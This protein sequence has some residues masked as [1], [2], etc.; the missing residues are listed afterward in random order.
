MRSS[1]TGVY[2]ADPHFAMEVPASRMDDYLEAVGN[3]FLESLYITRDMGI[4]HYVI[5]GDLFNKADTPGTV[6]NRVIDILAR[7]NDGSPWPFRVMM[8]LGNHDIFGHNRLTIERTTAET[9]N[10]TGVIDIFDED[11]E[12]GI[13][14]GHYEI[15]IEKKHHQSEMPIW[16]VHS[17]IVPAPF[18][19]PHIL[20]DDFVV[21][22]GTRLVISGHWHEGYPPVRRRDGVTFAN[23][24]SLGRTSIKDASHPVQIAVVSRDGDR[25]DVEYIPIKSAKRPEIVFDMRK[26]Q[27]TN[28]NSAKGFAASVQSARSTIERGADGIALVHHFAEEDEVPRRIVD[29]AVRQILF[30]RE[31]S[32]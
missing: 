8:V 27:P 18:L 10:K 11:E 12:L 30:F 9:L 15:N 20:V 25:I 13:Y 24:G 31:N 32:Q 5:L 7:G 22:E 14:A 23:P 4:D 2:V 19:G 28:G 16:A 3:K 6:R 26:G 29:E 1:T 17:Y 21:S